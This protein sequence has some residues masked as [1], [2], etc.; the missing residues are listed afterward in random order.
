MTFPYPS[1]GSFSLLINDSRFL[2]EVNIKVLDAH[3]KI[4]GFKKL[5]VLEGENVYP[6]N[7]NS[8]EEGMYFIS[9]E[10]PLNNVTLRHVVS[11]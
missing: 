7:V 5:N 11:E 10:T 9:L 8:L 4:V 2:G 6:L 1:D 3:G